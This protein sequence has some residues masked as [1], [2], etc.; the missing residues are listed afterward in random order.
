VI[1]IA[2]DAMGGDHAPETE[3]AGALAALAT[4]PGNFIVQLV[5]RTDLQSDAG[6]EWLHGE[7]DAMGVLEKI[8]ELGAESGDTVIIGDQ[9]LEYIPG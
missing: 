4:L 5:G 8:E 1:R 7:L 2:L 3:I 6:V 9:E